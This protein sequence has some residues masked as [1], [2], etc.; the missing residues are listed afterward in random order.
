MLPPIGKGAQSC[1]DPLRARTLK[2]QR[3]SQTEVNMA[4]R[5][6]ATDARTHNVYEELLR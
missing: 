6:T 1:L 2:R 3:E 5:D 4:D